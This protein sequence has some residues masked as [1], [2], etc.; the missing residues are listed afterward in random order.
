MK[1]NIE[2]IIHAMSLALD[3]A[4]NSYSFNTSVIENHTNVNYSNHNFFHH[5]LRTTYISLEIG[6]YLKISD[7]LLRELYV[8]SLLHDI[9]AANYLIDSHS[10]EE[11]IL[12][13]CETGANL[14]IGFPSFPQISNIIKYHH[15]NFDGSGAL[16]VLPKDTPLCS[17]ILRLADLVEI[18]YSEF[19]PSYL[20]KEKIVA[21][22]KD[23]KNVF[24]PPKLVDA[25]VAL[26]LKD[27]FWFNLENV[28]TMTFI[29][30]TVC[31]KIEECIGID[32]VL[33]IAYIF[34]GII[35]SKSTFTAKHSKN[36]AEL[37]YTVGKYLN[38][39]EEKAIKLKIAGLLHDIGKV[40]IP[41]EI[42]SKNASLTEDE[43]SIIKSHAYYTKLILNRV[44][45]IDDICAWASNHH[46]KLNGTGY[47][48]GLVESELTEECKILA[49]CDIY[50]AL[51][52]DRPYRAGLKFD[53]AF[54]ILYDMVENNFICIHA[55]DN[56]KNA[57]LAIL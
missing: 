32:D 56:L 51:T 15:E 10:Q 20:Q 22:V 44:E 16:N 1:V 48:E 54:S 25:F 5:S 2:K 12:G 35:D 38:Y 40:A 26:S 30:D 4:E 34:A 57:L 36:I 24:F 28:A 9:G 53:V 19:S 33:K 49:V 14:L 13:H 18:I 41:S 11:F 31:P 43:F 50:Q 52:E 3:L 23:K 46:E 55:V 42:L 37:A 8:A 17:Q 47:P 27:I 21:W 45:D 29:L 39:P 7:E 6:R